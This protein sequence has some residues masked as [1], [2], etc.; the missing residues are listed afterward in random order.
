M[1]LLETHESLEAIISDQ[2]NQWGISFEKAKE[3]KQIQKDKNGNNIWYEES[4][5][6]VCHTL[7]CH[8]P[9]SNKI[10]WLSAFLNR[11]IKEI[12][13]LLGIHYYMSHT[14]RQKDNELYPDL[15][16]DLGW[17]IAPYF[18]RYY[19]YEHSYKYWK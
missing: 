15:Y 7:F 11:T 9:I 12:N 5:A 18:V 8:L 4:L 1:F 10:E 14:K 19:K 6:A 2:L 17:V 3:A 16:N 13:C